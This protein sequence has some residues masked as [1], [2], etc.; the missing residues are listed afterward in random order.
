MISMP[1]LKEFIGNHSMNSMRGEAQKRLGQYT[2]AHL[3]SLM[4]QELH[5]SGLSSSWFD[6]LMPIILKISLTVRLNLQHDEVIDIR[7]FVKFKKLPGGAR[8]DSE[9]VYGVV[10]SKNLTSKH[11]QKHYH[12]PKI[13]LLRCAFEFERKEN[14]F[15][16]FDMLLMQEKEYISNLVNKVLA[17]NPNLV[18]VERSVARIAQ[19]MLIKNDITLITNM[20]PSVI[21]RIARSTAGH[22][23]VSLDQFILGNSA[24]SL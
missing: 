4:L 23:L 1:L 3:S 10:C 17:L 7:K 20:K 6:V 24:W 13:L 14:K 8:S 18:I 5:Q 16:S 19:E 21:N 2:T 22:Q 12:K 11:T 9:I 15:S